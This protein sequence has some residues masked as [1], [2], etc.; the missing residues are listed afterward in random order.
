M[1]AM[2]GWQ[3]TIVAPLPGESESAGLP[4]A[5]PAPPSAPG[6]DVASGL[7]WLLLGAALFLIGV[8]A[9]PTFSRASTSSF[10]LVWL[11]GVITAVALLWRWQ[12]GLQRRARERRRQAERLRVAEAALQATRA[13]LG[14]H[15]QAV[16][17]RSEAARVV[18]ELHDSV[19]ARLLSALALAQQVPIQAGALVPEG[20]P[21]QLLELRRQVEASLL[22]LRLSLDHLDRS[23]EAPLLRALADLRDHVEP[24]LASAGIRLQWQCGSGVDS[25]ALGSLTT[26]QLTRIA[27]ES[28]LNIARH[29]CAATEARVLL[30]LLDGET[31]RHLRLA[32]SDDGQPPGPAPTE[33]APTLPPLRSGLGWARLQ[34]QA[35]ELG[36][37]LVTGAQSDGWLVDL[38]LPL[39]NSGRS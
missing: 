16:N 9:W 28:L 3:P 35:T 12:V 5:L 37:Q 8:V 36:A 31:G 22:E 15:D 34:R 11:A 19:G 6:Q 17:R 38:V 29:A 21:Q 2:P 33:F 25:V 7:P 26:L 27:Q 32:I 4:M 24:L 14:Q 30:E 18:R 20:A 39:P 1:S 23:E 13:R 10:A